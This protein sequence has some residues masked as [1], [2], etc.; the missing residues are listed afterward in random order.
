MRSYISP[1]D[2]LVLLHATIA[3]EMYSLRPVNSSCLSKGKLNER[4]GRTGIESSAMRECP[5]M[6]AHLELGLQVAI[7]NITSTDVK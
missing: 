3:F 2:G 6:S 7:P 1:P 4:A 5:R